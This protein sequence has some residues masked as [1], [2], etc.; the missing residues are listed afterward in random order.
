VS[1]RLHEG[2]WDFLRRDADERE[3]PRRDVIGPLLEG[4]AA[5]SELGFKAETSVDEAVVRAPRLLRARGGL[6]KKPSRGIR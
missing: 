5:W 3:P 2:V 6:V 4:A 1:L